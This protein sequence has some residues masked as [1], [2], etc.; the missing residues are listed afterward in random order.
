MYLCH[1]IIIYFCNWA[2]S[3]RRPKIDRPHK[4]VWVVAQ[5]C[6]VVKAERRSDISIMTFNTPASNFK[7]Q[8]KLSVATNKIK[9][10]TLYFT[11]H[12]QLTHYLN[13]K[14]Y[15]LN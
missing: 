14:S 1:L 10:N 9:R 3:F 12:A 11:I 15:I 4:L 7:N 6:P 5:A 2:S 13:C 8:L